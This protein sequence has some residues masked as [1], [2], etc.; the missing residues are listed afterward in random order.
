MTKIQL[1]AY[2]III[3]IILILIPANKVSAQDTEL[4]VSPASTQVGIGQSFQVNITI[5]NVND[6][7]G[8]NITLYYPSILNGTSIVEGPFLKKAGVGTAWATGNFTD[9]Y[10]ATY[11]IIWTSC[12]ILGNGTGVNGNGTL[13]TVTFKTISTGTGVLQFGETELID[14]HW[15]PNYIPH[16]TE[17]GAVKVI[18]VPTDVAVTNVI[19]L[20]TVV[21]W[22]FPFSTRVT[23]K[24]EGGYGV[25]FN[26]TLYAKKLLGATRSIHLYGS[27]QTGWGLT[28]NS[29][30]SPGPTLTVSKGDLVNMTLTANDLTLNNFFIDYN[31]NG[32]PD[33]GEPKSGNFYYITPINYQFIANKSGTFNYYSQYYEGVMNG[34]FIVVPNYTQTTTIGT[35]LITLTSGASGNLTYAWNTS[36]LTNKGYYDIMAYAWPL[37][38]DTNLAN[39][40]FTY[41]SRVTV[42]IPGDLN[43]DRFVNSKDAAMIA[44]NWL[45][46][47]PPAPANADVNSDG[48]INSKDFAPISA[49]WLQDP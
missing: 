4:I 20:K 22:R 43:G 42:T 6:L 41:G 30:T 45:Q 9:H 31:G 13:E 8:W 27:N 10:N 19:P 38:G 25:S 23:V 29:I 32:A 36:G 14:S 49:N 1:K 3:T 7:K 26:V 34:K 17:N 48:V 5:S 28:P 35:Q 2:L 21:G 46:M 39:N 44:A 16:T 11:G 40:N 18:I 12:V 47:V 37:P 33:P 24:N 15:P